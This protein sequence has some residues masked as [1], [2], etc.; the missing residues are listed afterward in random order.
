MPRSLPDML[1]QL[2]NALQAQ[3]Y[4]YD[5]ATVAVCAAIVTCLPPHSAL[6]TLAL[7]AA[8]RERDARFDSRHDDTPPPPFVELGDDIPW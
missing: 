8:K 2:N 7:E 5:S 1:E 3:G 6:L 4:D